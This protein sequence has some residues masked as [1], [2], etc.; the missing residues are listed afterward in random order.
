MKAARHKLLD[1][2]GDL[3]LIGFSLKG[4]VIM[5]KPGHTHNTNF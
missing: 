2:I 5:N 1:V 3:A 4:K